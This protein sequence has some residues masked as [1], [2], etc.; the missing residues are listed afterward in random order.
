M[1]KISFVTRELIREGTGKY[2]SVTQCAE[3]CEDVC[4]GEEEWMSVHHQEA[5]DRFPKP[6]ATSMPRT[7][8][9]LGVP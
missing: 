9:F 5:R 3:L 7:K 2:M 6:K 4:C 8:G 1:N